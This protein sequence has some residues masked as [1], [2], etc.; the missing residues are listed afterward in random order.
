MHCSDAS[1]KMRTEKAK[2]ISDLNYVLSKQ[3]KQLLFKSAPSNTTQFASIEE[4]SLN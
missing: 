3:S 1:V 4:Y 2:R